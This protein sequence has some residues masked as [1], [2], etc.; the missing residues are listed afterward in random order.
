MV[1]LSCPIHKIPISLWSEVQGILSI[2]TDWSQVFL[3]QEHLLSFATAV[4]QVLFADVN[5][6]GKIY[7]IGVFCFSSGLYHSMSNDKL[8]KVVKNKPGIYFLQDQFLDFRME[9]H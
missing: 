7:L 8:A 6:S 5:G 1:R 9:V 4:F 3:Y 2:R